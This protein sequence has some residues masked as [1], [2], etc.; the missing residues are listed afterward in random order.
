VTAWA[1]SS[2]CSGGDC[3]LVA[4]TNG[5]HAMVLVRDSKQGDVGAGGHVQ[6]WAREEWAELLRAVRMG[7]DHPALEERDGE[8][9]V[10]LHRHEVLRFTLEEWRSFVA[11]AIAGE[12]EF[13]QLPDVSAWL[14]APGE[15]S[16]TGCCGES[17]HEDV[18]AGRADDHAPPLGSSDSRA[19][20]GQPGP[21]DDELDLLLISPAGRDLPRDAV[22]GF[23][24]AVAT[25]GQPGPEPPAETIPGKRGRGSD[26]DAQPE[27]VRTA[28]SPGW[29]P[30]AATGAGEVGATSSRPVPVAA[31]PVPYGSV[32]IR[33]VPAQYIV[34]A[35]PERTWITLEAIQG[36]DEHGMFV[37]AGRVYLGNDVAGHEVVYE[38]VGWDT[39][40]MALVLERVRPESEEAALDAALAYAASPL[41][42]PGGAS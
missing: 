8:M 21:L 23:P 2:R 10:G 22:E 25:A 33:R 32:V 42:P 30:D 35:A 13:G 19:A 40:A 11:G 29:R 26:A 7:E 31:E 12:L 1:R 15:P 34:E 18:P 28:E 38:V 14:A 20:T 3:V 27:G 9:L 41:V 16:P 37:S 36:S 17:C 5:D 24:E 4:R 39:R 6:T